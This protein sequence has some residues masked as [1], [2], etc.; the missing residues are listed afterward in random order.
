MGYPPIEDLLPK[1]GN[2]VYK[3]VRMAANRAVDLADAK[4]KLIPA[5]STPKV[6]TIALEEIRA[7]RV[8]A[9]EVTDIFK[10]QSPQTNS[11]NEAASST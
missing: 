3:L 11:E 4:P 2:S 10:D 1:A 6:T 8:V 5:S 7:G 9:K